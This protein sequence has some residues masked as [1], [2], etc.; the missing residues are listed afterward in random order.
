MTPRSVLALLLLSAGLYAQDFRAT[1][2]GTVTDPSGAA[3]P[4]ATV[5]ATNIA[6]NSTKETKTTSEGLFTIPYLEPGDYTIE[7]SAKGFQLMKRTDITLQVA[8]KLN[9]PIQMTVG[10]MTQEVT[11]TGQQEVID[12]ADASRGLVFDP[13][14]TQEYPLNGRQTY[15]L[16]SLTPGVV[17]TQEQFGASGFSGTRGWDV[18]NSYKI[19]GA[20]TGESL[21][22]L[23]GAPISD[24]G[25]SW[26]LAPNVE[27][28]QEFKVMTNTYDSSYGRFGGGVVNTTIKSGSNT[29]NGDVFD[30]WRNSVL[31]ANFFQNNV[32]GLKKGFHN[33]HQFGG[34][35]GGPIRKDK[36]FI[37]GSFEGWQEVVPFPA[38]ASTPNAILRDGQHFNDLGYKIFDPLTTHACNAA[39]EPCQGQTYISNP[40]PNNV[41][42]QNR[43]SPIGSKILS[44]FPTENGP[45]I[46]NNFIAAGN[47]G[48]YWYN[49]PMVRWDHVFGQNDKFYS[50]FTF[51]QG[52]EYRSST[53]FPKPAAT[54]NTNNER[55][56]KNI[57]VDW[58][59]VMSSAMVFDLRASFGRFVQTTPGYSDFSTNAK[60]LGMTG[61]TPSPSSPGDVAP[62]INLGN[63]SMPILSGG[64]AYSWNSYNQFNF[65]PS[66][67]LT[68]GSHT[69]RGGFEVNY[70]TNGN[71]N[72]GSSN[73]IFT[74]NSTWTQQL[75]ALHQNA[76]DGS[77]VASLLLGYPTGGS[78]S[79]ND[80]QYR[81]R[82]YY[83]FYVQDDWKVSSRLT[84]NVGLRYDV[85][86]PWLER[87]NR[88][89]RGWDPNF[90]QPNSDAILA[91]WANLKAQY[92][93]AN[94]NAKYPYPAPPSALTGGYLF[95]GVNGAPSRLYNTDW[96]N[97]QPRLGFAY[98]I[99]AKTVLRGGAG[100]YYQSSTQSGTTTGFTQSTGYTTSLDG[101]VTPAAGASLTGPYSL[102][103][104][105]PNGFA[106]P[107]GNTRG[108]QTNIGNGVSYDPAGFSIPRT[109]QYSFGIQ[110]ELFHS[111][112]AEVSY[113]GN[114]QNHIN[115]GQNLNHETFAAQQIAI[116]D[117]SYYSRSLPN[118]FFGF[119]PVTSSL[120]NSA[121]IAANNLFRPDPIYQGITNNLIQQGWYRSDQ[122]QV[123]FEQRAF[124]SAGGH[125]NAGVFTWVLSYAFSKAFEAN[126]RLNDWN[127]NEPIIKEIDNTDKAQNL[128]I[129]GVWDLPFGHEQRFLNVSNKVARVVVDNWRLTP[130][131]SYESGNPTGMPNL[132][133]FCGDWHAKAQNENSWINSDRTCYA[134]LANGNVLRTN[135]DRFSDIRDPSVGPFINVAMEKTIPMGE[136]Y[137]L[138]FR[139]E[140]FNLFNH[141][142][143]P[144]P[145]TDINNTLFGQ[146]PKSQLNFPRLIQL[147][148]KFYF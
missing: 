84:L 71:V 31:D 9:L 119:V 32:Q 72:T 118:P 21:F 45:G 137:K 131:L 27:A 86:I 22:L 126:H 68:H 66:V 39:T 58:T 96:T 56:D 33:Q 51:Q 12:T 3:I 69:L 104:P 95:P 140:S 30:Y 108:S 77:S 42:P 132:I 136:R 34:V 17:F 63:Y 103:N 64:T 40:F 80:S 67:T 41:I 115:L 65:T 102:V 105:F 128:S 147:A 93:A 7:V 5:K 145:N 15:M 11:V 139:A 20:R 4:N 28:V 97:I 16:M 114:Y 143:R 113:A 52:H 79:Y 138:Q 92:D 106:A 116:A 54:G 37:L 62:S 1:L 24:N 59:H 142:Q 60:T 87:Y 120:G 94:P 100:I 38:L 90:K 70:V 110:Q 83:G 8:M 13:I 123:R 14:K 144:G 134:Q 53:G 141:P 101:G 55:N 127:I 109:Y 49:Q 88:E 89:N 91:N 81:S 133:N 18:N 135:P 122:L 112:V 61:F 117:P 25:G 73:G 47:L 35:V 99:G 82:P 29:W 44:Y 85:Q 146:L 48:R 130:I 46:T 50:L 124:G 125:G 78:I 76:T 107:T 36:D 57:I 2:G 23:N 111:I 10:Q 148:A 75:P 6:V 98:R 74:F 43:I 121:N 19:N 26:Q 129:S